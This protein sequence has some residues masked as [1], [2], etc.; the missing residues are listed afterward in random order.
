MPDTGHYV[1]MSKPKVL[2]YY[3]YHRDIE[4]QLCEYMGIDP[5]HF[6]AYH[7]VV[8]GEYKD[9]WHELLD[10]H[11]TENIRN[12]S[13]FRMWSDIQSKEDIGTSYKIVDKYLQSD[14]YAKSDNARMYGIY[15][16]WMEK[17]DWVKP[18]YDAL[19]KLHYEYG[20][21]IYVWISW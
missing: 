21:E 17:R 16:R 11:D 4:P 15:R 12:D 6:R 13:F 8:G 1:H 7:N 3:E 2:T 10:I 5:K 9:F 20:E 19:D 18:L 14:Q